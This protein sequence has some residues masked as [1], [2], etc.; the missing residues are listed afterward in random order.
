MAADRPIRTGQ[1][2]DAFPGQGHGGRASP[3]VARP[4]EKTTMTRILPLTAL[5][6][7]ATLLTACEDVAGAID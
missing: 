4:R 2:D 3:Y 6:L 5:L 1:T 7:S